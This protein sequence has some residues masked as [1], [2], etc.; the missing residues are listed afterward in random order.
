MLRVTDVRVGIRCQEQAHVLGDTGLGRH[1]EGLRQ[2][3][4][5]A[6]RAAR[7][8]QTLRHLDD[9]FKGSRAF[10]REHGTRHGVHGSREHR[11]H[12]LLRLE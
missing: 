12:H 5:Q 9:P 10:A 11:L 7:R 8:Q 6:R 1:A 2:H 3:R 4:R